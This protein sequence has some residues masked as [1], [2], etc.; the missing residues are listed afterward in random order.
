LVVP[1]HNEHVEAVFARVQ[2]MLESVDR[3]GAGAAFEAWIL[4]DTADPDAILREELA[5]ARLRRVPGLPPVYYRRRM[6]KFRKKSGNVADFCKRWGGRY[7]YMVVLDADSVMDGGVMIELVRRMEAA[8]R[9]GILQAPSMLA[10]QDSLYG[11]IEQFSAA[12]YGPAVQAGLAYCFGGQ[13][14]FW[15]HNPLMRVAPL[16]PH[17]R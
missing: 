1:I 4:S 15:G 7:E 8:P 14:H 3:A 16:P 10:M 2:A 11:R 13:S 9:L 17:R 12:T 5:W 6:Q